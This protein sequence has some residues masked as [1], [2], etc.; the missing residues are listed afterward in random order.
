MVVMMMMMKNRKSLITPLT[1]VLTLGVLTILALLSPPGQRYL[2]PGTV[3]EVRVVNG[4]TDNSS[5]AV[6]IWCSSEHGDMGG[7]AL[8]EGDDFSWRVRTDYFW[9]TPNYL[10]TVKWDRKRKKFHAFR[11]SRDVFRCGPLKKCS[12]L[13]TQNGFFFSND[14]V[15]W[16]K[17]FSWK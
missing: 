14:E 15:N 17:D 11:V 5:L 2:E 12:W 1:V 7:R 13:V 10:C 9:G 4:F 8:Q 6:V 16:T 3:Y